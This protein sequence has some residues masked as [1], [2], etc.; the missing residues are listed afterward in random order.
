MQRRQLIVFLLLLFVSIGCDHAAKEV[1]R[2]TLS[3]TPVISWAGD[4]VRFQLAANPG[5]FLS[6]GAGM[7]EAVRQFL[8][9]GHFQMTVGQVG[10]TVELNSV[11]GR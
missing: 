11:G 6:L 2:A 4:A 1:A 8:F 9:V 10:Q 5:A 7:P 3:G